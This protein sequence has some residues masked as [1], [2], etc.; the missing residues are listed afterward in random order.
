MKK[1]AVIIGLATV[2]AMLISK[3]NAM[4]NP[5]VDCESDMQCG[6]EKAGFILPL[7]VENY[8]IRAMDGLFEMRFPL[9]DGREVI[10]RKAKYC[11]DEADENGIKDISGDYNNYPVKKTI[12]LKNGVKFAVRGEENNY[13]VV[14]FVAD[15]G[16]YAFMCDEGLKFED[17]EQ[18]YELLTEAEAPT[19]VEL[20]E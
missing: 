18:L 17:I 11:E 5:W 4:Q 19:D 16:Y 1:S 12:E 13:K 3:A 10:V 20:G 2:F 6:E 7:R 9:N 8:T 14:N 15:T